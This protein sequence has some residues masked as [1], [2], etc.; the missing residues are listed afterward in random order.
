MVN[1]YL[2]LADVF[3]TWFVPLFNKQQCSLTPVSEKYSLVWE[4]VLY[5]EL[6]QWMKCEAYQSKRDQR[7]QT[8]EPLQ[9]YNIVCVY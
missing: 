6:I 4:L 3:L 9:R 2:S 8:A 5:Y 1:K 7:E